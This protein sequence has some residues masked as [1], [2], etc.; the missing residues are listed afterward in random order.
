MWF[1][2]K[3]IQCTQKFS[4]THTGE[5]FNILH[6]NCK[7][8]NIIYL[9]M[10]ICGLQYIVNNNFVLNCKPDL[11]LSRHL[12]SRATMILSALKVLT[13]MF[14][15][16]HRMESMRKSNILSWLL[17]VWS[18]PVVLGH[19]VCSIGPKYI[20][21]TVAGRFFEWV[22]VSYRFQQ[23]FDSAIWYIYQ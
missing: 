9:G 15:F 3:N 4:S 13:Q 5:Q 20:F 18:P 12:R 10:C 7:T 19:T 6:A 22:W 11:P 21:H 16:Y 23:Y 17:F 2:T 1:M 14:F 8:E